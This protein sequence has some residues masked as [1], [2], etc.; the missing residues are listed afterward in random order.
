MRILFLTE[1]F[2]PETNAAA[3]RVYERACYWARW[4][5]S[6][7]VVTCAPNFP[8]GKVYP[9]YRNRW[10]QTEMMNGIRVVRVKTFIRPNKGVV[11]RTLDFLSFMVTG[12]VAGLIQSRPDVVVS[13]SPQFFTAVGAWAVSKCRRLPY[14][15]ELGDLWPA[16]IVAVGALKASPATRAIEALELFLYRESRAVVALTRAFK[17]DLVRRRIPPEK[18]AVILNGVDLPRYAPRPRDAE[19]AHEWSLDDAFVVGYIGTHGLAHG[20]ENVLKAAA[21]LREDRQVKFLFVGTGAAKQALVAKAA[22]MNVPNVVFVPPQPK[23]RMPEFWSLCDVALIHLKDTKVFESVI[24]SKMFEA[25]GMGIPLLLS[26]PDGEARR[27]LENA[28]AGLWTPPE[29]PQALATAISTL[30]GDPALR[31]RLAK[32]SHDAA[33]RHSRERQARDVIAVLEESVKGC[34]VPLQLR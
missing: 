30:R 11:A 34:S 4:R 24:P 8:E 18:I 19:L 5:H 10:Y 32:Q 3:T 31:A 14:V 16:S 13:T 28:T 9:G 26:A 27:V 25:M 22:E 29:N 21:L 6:V 15:F 12:F 33:P 23:E 7:T 2:P 20:L 17:D 1:N